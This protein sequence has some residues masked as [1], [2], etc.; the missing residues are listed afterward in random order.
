MTNRVT[1]A[2]V[3][4]VVLQRSVLG[5]AV[6][7]TLVLPQVAGAFEANTGNEDLAIRWDNTVRV[8][9]VQRA[10]AQDKAI[11]ANPN[12]D[13]GDRNFP[14]SNGDFLRFDLLSE[15]DLVWKKMLGFRVSAAGWYDGGYRSLNNDSLAT[16]NNLD[17]GLPSYGLSDY[18]NRY[19]QGPSAEFLDWFVFTKFNVGEAPVNIKLGQNTVYW[20]ESLLLGGAVHGVSYSQNPIDIWK[21]LATPGAEAKELFRPRLGFNIQ[22]TVTDTLSIAGQYFFNWQNFSNQAYRY[23]ESGTYLSIQ[24][25]LLWGG[26]SLVFGPNPARALNP[27]GPQYAR[28]WHGKDITPEENSGNWGLAVR[29]SPQWVDG[30]LGAYYRKTYDMQPQVMITPGLANLPK[31]TCIAIGGISFAP[32]A[33]PPQTVAPCI[34]NKNATNQADLV[35]KGKLGE[36]NVAFGEDI[37]I[38]GISLSKQIFGLSLGAEL[39]YRQNMP[40]VSDPVTVLPAPLVPST[41]G[42]IATTDVPKHGTPGAVGDTMHGLVNL[43]GIIGETPL[44]DSAGWSTEL[45]WM[46][47]LDVNQNEAV[48]KG[49]KG[50]DQIDT[51]DKNYFGLGINFTPTWYQVFP[52]VD[53]LAPLSWSQGF[54]NSAVTAGGSD[55][56]GTFGIGVAADIRQKYRVDLK[57]VG[58]YGDYSKCPRQNVTAQPG[59]CIGASGSAD[60]FNGVNAIVSDRDF[61]SLTFK[62]TF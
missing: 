62:T 31:A 21:G 3:R 50:Y 17:N 6:A 57:Y 27:A 25:A 53:I 30:T 26:D 9:W 4:G 11:L 13:D 47:W 23:P 44:F 19:A 52:S 28:L 14:T 22:S 1:G 2:P 35:G 49:R 37:D 38:Y 46:T 59:T 12:Y 40:L 7:A 56:A 58:F 24:D 54:A 5:I 16:R 61:V 20:G 15:F 55:G 32:G 36:Y 8:N 42:A 60:I 51:V 43:L 29:W 18:S 33:A 39:S 10:E 48:F 41:P 45:T 34:I